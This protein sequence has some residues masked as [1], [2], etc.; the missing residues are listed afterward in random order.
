VD[1]DGDRD[2][3][4]VSTSLRALSTE[5]E[6]V[7]QLLDRIDSGGTKK[8]WSERTGSMEQGISINDKMFFK[9]KLT[10]IVMNERDPNDIR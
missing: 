5:N 9:S 4:S 6:R 10:D 3:N 7:E 8:V 1:N 2:F